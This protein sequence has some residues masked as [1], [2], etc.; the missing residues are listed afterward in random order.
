MAAWGRRLTATAL[1]RLA[2]IPGLTVYGPH[3]PHGAPRSW[4]STSRTATPVELAL[5]LN[6]AGVEARA[7]CYRATLAHR[8]LGLEPLGSCRLS[9]YL[10]HTVEDVEDAVD[11][12]AD[13]VTGGPTGTRGGS[14]EC[15]RSDSPA[16]AS[17]VARARGAPA[18][19]VHS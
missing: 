7:G 17:P 9:F 12:L 1:E 16:P 4:R 5:G 18:A 11:A 3:D 6:D 19:A 2:A 15:A 10:Y 14:S 13:V 8:A